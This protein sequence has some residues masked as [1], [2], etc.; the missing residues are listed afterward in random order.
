M[1]PALSQ[2]QS[3]ALSN[4]QDCIDPRRR[5]QAVV[6]RRN[7]RALFDAIDSDHSGDLDAHE[8]LTAL[9]GVVHNDELD[10]EAINELIRAVDENGDGVAQREEFE[11][12]VREPPKQALSPHLVLHFDMNQTVLMLDSAIG[13]DLGAM[14]NQTIA[15]AAWGRVADGKDGA[16]P[17]WT[18]V[19]FEPEL[20]SP[21]EGLKTFAQYASLVTPLKGLTS[22][23]IK[24]T[25]KRRRRMMQTF[26][27]AGQPGARFSA[28]KDALVKALQLD[29]GLD[30]AQ[31]E[32][33]G[34]VPGGVHQL[35]PSFLHLIRALKMA[36]TS[37]SLS[38]RTFGGD[39]AGVI[40][41]YN[42]LCEGRHPLFG[43]DAPK[44]VLDGSDGLPDMRIKMEGG[45]GLGTW[46]RE[47]DDQLMLVLGT[48]DQPPKDAPSS[49]GFY[50]GK[51]GVRILDGAKA[52][53]HVA[54]VLHKPGSG[55]AL[56]LR[57]YY[58]AW[59]AK[60]CTADGG[61]PLYLEPDN[62]D[63]LQI[64]FDDHILP[65]DA[66]IVD[67][68]RAHLPTAPPLPIA[69]TFNTHLVRAEP[70]KSILDQGFF[71]AAIERSELRWR[72]TAAH[73]A[74]L[75]RALGDFEKLSAHL[76]TSKDAEKK[77][78]VSH[79][80]TATVTLAS[81]FKDHDHPDEH[82]H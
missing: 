63:L 70:F 66:H 25:K 73:R 20:T 69:A 54:S 21:E 4:W 9:A 68:R 11:N 53:A 12:L 17:T 45:A 72:K 8:L 32:A 60:A 56:G 34:L 36:G 33:A 61:K 76:K 15:N 46:I 30:A 82:L 28:N 50:D 1:G 71:T 75:A 51:E 79:M 52:I 41:E 6:P 16:E 37:F 64:F 81:D 35:L 42:A 3:A 57:D 31:C 59:E 26:A 24:A 39:S 62:P 80:E 65:S 43:S 14:L 19:S 38:F 7:I 55:A 23:E 48:H 58:P 18:L 77:T 27:D 13:A 5:A 22:D 40:K 2:L 29:A 47:G 44:V 10:E 67:V 49:R 78:Y 74:A